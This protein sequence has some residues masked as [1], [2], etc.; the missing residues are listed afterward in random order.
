MTIPKNI[1]EAP[2]GSPVL[3]LIDQALFSAGWVLESGKGFVPP[4]EWRTEAFYTRFGGGVHYGRTAAI[5]ITA[6]AYDV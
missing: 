6:A 4:D 2:A 3:Q 1:T 5:Q